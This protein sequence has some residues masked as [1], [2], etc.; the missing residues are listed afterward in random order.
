MYFVNPVYVFWIEHLSRA[1]WW[2]AVAAWIKTWVK[3]ILPTSHNVSF[4]VD[5][6]FLRHI[7][8]MLKV[9]WVYFHFCP[10]FSTFVYVC[11]FWKIQN[12]LVTFLRGLAF[13]NIQEWRGLIMRIGGSNEH[14][15]PFRFCWTSRDCINELS[16]CPSF[17]RWVFLSRIIRSK[18]W[19]FHVY[20]VANFSK[21]LMNKLTIPFNHLVC[22]LIAKNILIF[23]FVVAFQEL[24]QALA[25]VS[26]GLFATCT[27]YFRTLFFRRWCGSF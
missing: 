10:L 23:S 18:D 6:Y 16:S 25:M 1:E 2:I 17:P 27:V 20:G 15:R 21:E 3:I 8:L 24:H 26:G 4:F 14:L 7:K 13:W 12:F 9:K 5:S 22:K 19:Y 11:M